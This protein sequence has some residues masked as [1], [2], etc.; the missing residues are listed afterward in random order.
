MSRRSR[1][2]IPMFECIKKDHYLSTSK[3]PGQFGLL[4]PQ[5]QLQKRWKRNTLPKPI[6]DG[7][8]LPFTVVLFISLFRVARLLVP[9]SPDRSLRYWCIRDPSHCLPK[10]ILYSIS[11]LVMELEITFFSNAAEKRH[12]ATEFD[13]NLRGKRLT[14]ICHTIKKRSLNADSGEWTSF[15]SGPST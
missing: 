7:H 15:L 1:C 10:L 4:L 9:C 3:F 8:A 11:S 12:V 2:L 14:K 13:V 5:W 6:S